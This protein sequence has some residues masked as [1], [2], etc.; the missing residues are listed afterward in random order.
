MATNTGIHVDTTLLRTA[1]ALTPER[2]KAGTT[3]AFKQIKN[4][5]VADARDEAPNDTGNLRRQINGTANAVGV[6]LTDNAINNGFNY[7]YYIHEIEGDKYLD[8]T[9]DE[10]AVK[11]QLE[12]AIKQALRGVWGG[13]T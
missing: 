11:V 13:G 1:M 8:R 7:A 6:M 5:W 10:D 12:E 4:D 9:I 3:E 2:T